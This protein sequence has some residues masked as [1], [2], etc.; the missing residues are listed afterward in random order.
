MLK[1]ILSLLKKEYV[2]IYESD[3]SVKYFLD[4]SGNVNIYNS[5]EELNK[6]GSEKFGEVKFKAIEYKKHKKNELKRIKAEKK[7]KS[8]T[9]KKGS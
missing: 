2:L 4:E 3:G 1:Q 8:K 7:E 9:E 6:I 5:V